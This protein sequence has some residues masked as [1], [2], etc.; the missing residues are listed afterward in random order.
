MTTWLTLLAAAYGALTAALLPRARYRLAAPEG[1][2]PRTSCPD[3]H[4]L[5]PAPRSWLGR[6]RCTE[7]GPASSYGPGTAGFAVCGAAICAALAAAVGPRPEL[8]AWLL[9]TPLCLLLAS[10][11]RETRRLPDVL[12]LP[13]ALLT[14]TAL[15]CAALFPRAGGDWRTA[16][17]GGAALAFAYGA[18]H[19]ANPAALGYGDVKLAL[20]LGVALGWYGWG[21][22]LLGALLGW[23]PAGVWGAVL[24]LT[25][26]RSRQADIALG[27]SL[28]CGALAT[29]L[30]HGLAA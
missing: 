11:D 29:V 4:P 7:C 30:L 19:F 22:L 13:L 3:G 9:A 15:A 2:P 8:A 18:I 26:R 6:A 25:R 17:L 10:V 5:G 21:A 1:A 14:A 16:L 12:T 28:L 27:P 20:A 24:L 23:L